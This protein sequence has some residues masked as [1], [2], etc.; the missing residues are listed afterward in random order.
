MVLQRLP[1]RTP[2]SAKGSLDPDARVSEPDYQ[3]ATRSG[4]ARDWTSTRP[5]LP[6]SRFAAP[7]A[8]QST[9]TRAIEKL[10]AQARCAV[11]SADISEIGNCCAGDSA[12]YS[13]H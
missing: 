12:R 2:L 6:R 11:A 7:S 13:A 10:F 4:R 8:K 5:R 1:R 9:A 3:A